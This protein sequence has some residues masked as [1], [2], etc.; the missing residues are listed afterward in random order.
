[1][2]A[3]EELAR[4]QIDRLL[5]ASG[6]VVQDRA[7]FN[8]S[9]AR[10][11]AVREF[12]LSTGEADYL[13]F[14]D[15]R[16]AGVVEAK[17]AGSTLSGVAEQTGRYITGV[18]AFLPRVGEPLPFAYES[19]GIETMFRDQRDPE[20]RSRRVYTFH[21]PEELAYACSRP[22]TLRQRLC[23]LPPL[24]V[25]GLRQ[26]QIEAVHGLEAAL[27]HNRPRSLVQ[28]ATGSGKT[29][30]AVT[31]VYRL[32]KFGGAK[33]VLFL[34]DRN[35]LGRQA[36]REFSQYKPPDD[37][38]ALAALYNIQ[39]LTT[40]ALDDVSKVCI[41]TIQRLYSML[42]GEA[43]YEPGNEERSL[44]DVAPSDERPR[45]IA[46]NPQLPI[47]Y[48]DFI[49][50][51]ECHRSIYNLWR[52]VL[53]Y[54]DA[55][56]IGLTAT[57]SKQTLGFFYQNLVSEYGH[58]RAVADG[59]NVNYDVYRIRTQIT[60]QGG[61]VEAG[62]QVDRRDRLTRARRWELLDDD[63]EY[64]PNQL[65][66]DV[67]APDQIRTVI[68]TFRDKL[69]EIFPGRTEAPKTLIFAKDDSHAEDIVQIVREEFGKGNEFCRKIT[70]RTTGD[71][72][73]N[74]ISAFRNSYH[75]RIAVSVDMISTGTDIKPLECLLFM[76]DVRSRVYFE[77][78]KGRGTRTIAPDDLLGVTPD[79]H[80]KDR[81]VIVDAVGV[82]ESDKG[83]SRPLERRPFVRF[84]RLLEQVA[85]GDRS[86]DSVSSLAGR[87]A[88]LSLTMTPAQ[89]Q[90]VADLA[91]APLPEIA[92]RLL[93]ALDPDVRIERARTQFA[94]DTLSEE[95]VAQVGQALADAACQPFNDPALRALLVDLQK[96]SEQTLD[97]ES[98]DA[99][100][101]AGADA[102]ATERAR[103]MV[104]AFRQF[105]ADHRDELD[106]LQLLYNRPY[107]Q[108]H[109]T[110]E[111]IKRLA[112]AI[113]A[114]PYGLTTD[115]LWQAYR[116]L[117]ASRVRGAGPARLLTDLIALLR[118]A[119]GAS[120]VLEPYPLTVQERFARWL[121]GRSFTPE[122]LAWLELMRDYIA[123]SLALTWEDLHYAPFLERGGPG[124]LL[125]L[126]GEQAEPLLAELNE[127]LVA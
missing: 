80:R 108:R 7:Q 78:M 59:V 98:Q 122:Q 6:W 91:G 81:F 14:V 85:L 13:L 52:Q 94:T 123:A 117:E 15:R 54:F 126:F 64:A 44:F 118:Y 5:Q 86:G 32:L 76:R 99:L 111:Q 26:C 83:D 110:Y 90:Q 102:Q 57:P 58:E 12:P 29:Y 56:L 88:R 120:D 31:L 35:N 70:Y 45:E 36:L 21:R 38:R 121:N 39:H 50:T 65:D 61:R 20:P 82:T 77:Q 75:P 23:R 96:R 106:A 46:Y 84:D 22:D 51:D 119:L 49:I 2:P 109:A 11:V 3:P 89:Q 18:P 40:N 71:T 30:A 107:A 55:F 8:L 101:F 116:Q 25:A 113:E 97:T 68:A 19:T 27:A 24:D 114:P 43:E 17:P 37:N 34:V 60:E 104:A 4:Q 63:L 28:M 73:E 105:I 10:G 112:A 87:L 100:L 79:A 33:R 92:G 42:R 62:H 93:D 72:P 103:Q 48:F 41:T 67:V 47:G 16:A 74:L 69:P 124:R 95:Q 1:M 9:A 127:V 125:Q 115:G 53:E 66:R